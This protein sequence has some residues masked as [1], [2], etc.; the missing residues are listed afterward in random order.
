VARERLAAVSIDL[1]P[2]SCYYRIHGLGPHPPALAD[3]I[4]R[5][6]LP[7]YLDVLHAHQVRA[8][9]FVVAANLT[10][11]SAAAQSARAL[12]RELVDAGHEVANHTFSH[13]YELA[14]LPR[15]R[16][17]EEIG[18]A[19]DVLAEAAGVAPVGFRAP[20]YAMSPAIL[21]ELEARGYEYDSSA[22]PAPAYY[23]AKAAV[24]GGL[25]LIG[26]RSGAVLC[27]PRTLLAPAEP[28]RPDP[29][30]P[31]RRGSST[32]IEIPLA[33]TPVLRLPV[34]GTSLLIAPA[35]LR[36]RWIDSMR[37]RTLFS[38]GLHGID[39]I[40][41]DLDGVPA[42]LVARQPDLSSSLGKKRGALEATLDRLSLDYR[43][44]PL[45]EAA[46]E[47]RAQAR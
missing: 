21:E 16:L 34:I 35:W 18:Q 11:G 33:V 47:A 12:I 2:I 17:A 43:M 3:V 6:A 36:D 20:G 37:G 44:V 7:R 46:A 40:D 38:L 24:M 31:W 9:F 41:A 8:T 19:H 25:R 4:L 10:G 22:F 15:A 45:R 26:R 30:A 27:D 42:P 23:A 5:R 13:P 1:D 32:L 39:L 14:R 28:Y 29:A